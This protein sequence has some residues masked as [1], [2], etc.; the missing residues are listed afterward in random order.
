[1]NCTK[2]Y[3][4][5]QFNELNEIFGNNPRLLEIPTLKPRLYA[6]FEKYQEAYDNWEKVAESSQKDSIIKTACE[7]AVTLLNK[8]NDQKGLLDRMGWILRLKPEIAMNFFTMVPLNF[9]PP[10]EIIKKL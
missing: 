4:Q 2:I 7:E 10:D 5:K 6:A 3:C 8:F 9:I 1:M